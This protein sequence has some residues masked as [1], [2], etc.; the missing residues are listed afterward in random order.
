[1]GLK[2]RTCRN[3]WV[4]NVVIFYLP[5]INA[6]L[7]E[8]AKKHWCI[9]LSLRM[10]LAHLSQCF[11]LHI[12]THSVFN[13][14]DI[15]CFLVLRDRSNNWLAHCI[16]HVVAMSSARA[17]GVL[18]KTKLWNLAHHILSACLCQTQEFIF[19]FN[20]SLN[21]EFLNIHICE[22]HRLCRG[23]RRTTVLF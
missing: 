13:A 1:M 17:L 9:L 6:F 11:S 5:L 20:S 16:L 7:I 18:F 3:W 22:A 4:Q 2:K 19:S 8:Q 23:T 14:S 21:H 15:I 12:S 10:L